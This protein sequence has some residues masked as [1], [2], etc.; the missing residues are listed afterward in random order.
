MPHPAYKILFVEDSD[1]YAL[2]MTRGIHR[3]TDFQLIWRARDGLD[4]I[5][6][7]SGTGEYGNREKFPLPDVMLLDIFL[8]RKDGWEVL[9]WLKDQPSKPVVILMT[10][11]DNA[12]FRKKALSQGAD[13][14]QVKPYEDEALK[15]FLA[16]LKSFV[17]GR[18]AERQTVANQ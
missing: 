17:T 16:W 8:P 14:F 5:R 15:A 10:V 4:A 12:P 2:I 11:L 3:S 13:E 7:L 9:E 18:R 1:D 6:Y